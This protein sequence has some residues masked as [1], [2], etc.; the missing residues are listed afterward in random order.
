[1]PRRKLPSYMPSYAPG[2][3]FGPKC[4]RA[5]PEHPSGQEKTL[6]RTGISRCRAGAGVLSPELYYF[7]RV[8][9]TS[10]F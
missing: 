5:E 7:R 9:E 8:N 1:M 6:A 2:L 4:I 10:F 3:A